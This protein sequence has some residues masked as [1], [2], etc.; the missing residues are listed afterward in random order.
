MP[1]QQIQPVT[2][3][4]PRGIYRIRSRNLD[5]GVWN[6]TD[7]FIGIREKF[8]STYL[9]TEYLWEQGP[10]HGTVHIQ[11]RE[12]VATLLPGVLVTEY[13]GIICV[14]CRHRMADQWQDTLRTHSCGC[15]CEQT[16]TIIEMNQ[17]LYNV[18]EQ[19]EGPETKAAWLRSRK[20]FTERARIRRGL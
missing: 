8:G 6:E 20:Y 13:L 2:P 10:P 19:A 5:V 7:G 16:S 1:V 14:T 17:L 3:L 4:V 18:L 9:F 12:H 11:G 15:D